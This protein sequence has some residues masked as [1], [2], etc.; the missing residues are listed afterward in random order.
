MGCKYS[1]R[2]RYISLLALTVLVITSVSPAAAQTT[3]RVDVAGD[4]SAFSV[5]LNSS[6]LGKEYALL[7]EVKTLSAAT[8]SIS[9]NGPSGVVGKIFVKAIPANQSIDTLDLNPLYWTPVP[10]RYINGDFRAQIITGE[11]PYLGEGQALKCPS[12]LGAE[13]INLMLNQLRAVY[14]Q[15]F[16]KQQLC[17][18][19]T[20]QLAGF[21]VTSL[22]DYLAPDGETPLARGVVMRDACSKAYK[23]IV[24]FRINP[25]GLPWY[26]YTGLQNIT[27]TFSV[28]PAKPI[29]AGLKAGAWRLKRSEGRDNGAWIL[30]TSALGLAMDE[31]YGAP[32][33]DTL[34][35]QY[36]KN[37]QVQ[38]KKEYKGK[39]R[40]L[41]GSKLLMI[42]KDPTRKQLNG[43]KKTFTFV[44]GDS[45]YSFC[46]SLKAEDSCNKDYAKA[47][48]IKCKKVYSK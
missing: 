46:A 20:A 43:K 48:G 11:D 44:N 45:A 34:Y 31:K 19:L 16:T 40:I 5:A 29:S 24:Q 38:K 13:E 1:Q 32:G 35:L 17:L 9:L 39:T 26:E 25:T 47:T 15:T 14:G 4:G 10:V 37:G 23:Y 22:D 12:Y 7:T 2:K 6:E 28:V 42:N 36:W 8:A 21:N 27:A 3:Q 33:T 41:Y 30:L 18:L